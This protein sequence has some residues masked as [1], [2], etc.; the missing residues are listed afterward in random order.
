M[1]PDQEKNMRAELAEYS[2]PEMITL[3]V[4]LQNTVEELNNWKRGRESSDKALADQNA[5]LQTRLA[6]MEDEHGV[7]VGEVEFE[8]LQREN[9][10]LQRKIKKLRK[11]IDKL[12]A[13]NEKYQAKLLDA[14]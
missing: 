9:T 4:K 10:N 6:Q 8:A 1:T 7:M 14:V 3:A 2:K 5:A 11:R 12:E 13:L